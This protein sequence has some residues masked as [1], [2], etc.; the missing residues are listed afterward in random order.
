MSSRAALPYRRLEDE[1]G[2]ERGRTPFPGGCALQRLASLEPE[3]GAIAILGPSMRAQMRC[4]R[5]QQPPTQMAL[6]QITGGDQL[7]DRRVKGCAISQRAERFARPSAR[8]NAYGSSP[9]LADPHSFR[10]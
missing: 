3:G 2:S 1:P 10:Q 4:H 9:H 5:T 8:V 6:H 7:A